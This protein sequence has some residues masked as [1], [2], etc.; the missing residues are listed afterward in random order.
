MPQDDRP[1]LV[2]ATE[3]QRA[4]ASTVVQ[5]L[6]NP[7]VKGT[8]L[9]ALD[10][11][12]LKAAEMADSGQDL[13]PELAKD[14]GLAPETATDTTEK[15]DDRARDPITGKFIA[16]GTE[17]A[18]TEEKP[19]GEAVAQPETV[20][21]SEYE[22][23]KAEKAKKDQERLDKTWENVN[24][25]KEELERREKELTQRAQQ[26]QRP[27]VQPQKRQYSSIQLYEASQDF[28][29]R[30]KQ[31]LKLYQE[32]GDDRHLDEFNKQDQLAD[33]A[34]KSSGQFYQ[35]EQKENQEIQSA[36]YKETWESHCS[37]AFETDP[38]L[39]DPKSD[40][41]VAVNALL[42]THG[43]VFWSIPDGFRQAVEIAKTRIKAS[44]YDDAIEAN[45][46]LKAENDRL[47]ALSTPTKG[48]PTGAPTG[49]AYDKMSKSE[50]DAYLM[51]AAAAEDARNGL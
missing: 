18:Q 10:Q 7:V 51:A 43:K 40:L 38:D 16:T 22:A 13:T 44:G 21:P 12:L 8:E 42:E 15:K 19:A 14:I 9:D 25:R 33:E 29:S 45:K 46:K 50:Q 48:S 37:K 4:N 30:A 35:I 11:N 47:T 28:R 49:K 39:V 3:A 26:V 1:P 20:L 24:L 5:E 41:A 34:F 32:T 2:A 31:E 27:Q 6:P 23:K 36:K 17:T